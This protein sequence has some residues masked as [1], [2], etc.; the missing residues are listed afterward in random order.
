MRRYNMT[1]ILI[2]NVGRTNK[3]NCAL[4]YSTMETIKR[5]IP[6]TEFNLM[7]TEVGNKNRLK[8]KK[9]IV[10]GLHI[11]KSLRGHLIIK[12]ITL[13]MYHFF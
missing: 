10:S 3:G 9:Q 11:Q 12:S 8:I 4:V 6:N 2:L 7:G 1:K 5:F 13:Y